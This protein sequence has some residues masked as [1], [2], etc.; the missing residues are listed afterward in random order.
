MLVVTA[1][2][3]L[4]ADSQARGTPTEATH[5][6]ADNAGP[7]DRTLQ[8][9]EID[10]WLRRLVG[11]YRYEGKLVFP[12]VAEIVNGRPQKEYEAMWFDGKGDC[13]GIGEGPGVQCI[14]NVEWPLSTPRRMNVP[15]STYAPAMTLYGIDPGLPGIRYLQVNSNGLPE[16]SLARPEGDR[17][18]FITPC[19]N[20]TPNCRRIVKI[21]ADSA[22]HVEMILET[23]TN[24]L[25]E[26][27]EPAVTITFTLLRQEPEPNN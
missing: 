6:R 16:G 13:T 12:F 26:Q 19:V 7:A 17:I 3:P 21:S 9:A 20:A 22:G 27:L 24:Y 1:M 8:L 25:G 14:M 23:W 2:A 5:S 10:Q 15:P 18:R 11:R 4:E